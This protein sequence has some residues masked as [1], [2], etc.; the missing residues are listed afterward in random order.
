[1]E[2]AVILGAGRMPFGKLGG[3]LSPLSTPRLG[4]AEILQRIV[5]GRDHATICSGRGQGDAVLVEV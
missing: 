5:C 3:T 1:M 2:R 4:G